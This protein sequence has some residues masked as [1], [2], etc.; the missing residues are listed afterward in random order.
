MIARLSET[1]FE[2][3][4][5]PGA[6]DCYAHPGALSPRALLGTGQQMRVFIQVDSVADFL[7]A[8]HIADAPTRTE[9]D[10]E[11]EPLRPMRRAP[12]F[13]SDG[14]E[15][16]VIERHGWPG[17]AAPTPDVDRALKSLKHLEHFRL[18]KRDWEDDISGIDHTGHL[19]DAAVAELG[20]D[21]ACSLFF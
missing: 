18:R 12:A 1:G 5:T 14:A 20:Q 8:W 10:I 3:T 2:R 6:P 19:I 17:F 4:P 11:G 15:M 16:W 13:R 7:A 21:L 9:G